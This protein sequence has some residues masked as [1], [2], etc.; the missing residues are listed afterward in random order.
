MGLKNNLM[1]LVL[2]WKQWTPVSYWSQL[3]G[4]KMELVK[5]TS[6]GHARRLASNVDFSTCPDGRSLLSS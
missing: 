5:T 2:Y 4:F 1:F 6:A 3:A